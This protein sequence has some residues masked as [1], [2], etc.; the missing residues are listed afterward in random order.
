MGDMMSMMIA[1]CITVRFAL[2]VCTHV[3]HYVCVFV[4]LAVETVGQVVKGKKKQ[5]SRCRKI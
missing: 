1:V 4:F 5:A 2:V 3:L